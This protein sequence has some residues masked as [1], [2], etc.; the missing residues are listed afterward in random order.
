MWVSVFYT[1]SRY[2]FDS[3][4]VLKRIR[5]PLASLANVAMKSEH[6][7]FEKADNDMIIGG[8]FTAF[9]PEGRQFSTCGVHSMFQSKGRV[10]S[11][12]FIAR[13][14]GMSQN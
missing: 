5:E 1:A 2:L 3:H 13:D 7:V 9:P 8:S 6:S 12:K 14:I 11:G 4:W 10:L